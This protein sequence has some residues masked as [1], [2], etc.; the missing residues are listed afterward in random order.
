MSKKIKSLANSLHGII[1]YKLKKTLLSN[2]PTLMWIEPTN[3]C[4]LKCIMCPNSV[5]PKE[6]Y[7]F[8]EYELFKKIIDEAKYF[9]GSAF[10]FLGGESLLHKDIFKMIAYAKSNGIRPLL[11]TNATLLNENNIS[12]L[13]ETGLDYISL[14]MDG[15]DK[16]TYEKVRVNAKYEETLGNIINLLKI[17]KARNLKKPYTVI[18]TL[19]TDY[20]NYKPDT[21]EE[22]RFYALFEGLPVDEIN[23]R[24][25]HAW[26]SNL[27][28]TDKY[29]PKSLGKVY[30][31][32]SF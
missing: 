26:G 22:K 13:F 20:K 7:G 29:V 17:K 8:M 1:N 24:I 6:K 25:P 14:S 32:C 31:P 21:A 27:F 18:Q 12:R 5:M 15:F 19:L 23:V 16:E 10:I 2:P 11:H 30:S 3:K 9:I 28:E 4:N